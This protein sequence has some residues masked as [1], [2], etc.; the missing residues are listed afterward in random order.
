MGGGHFSLN[1]P[2]LSSVRQASTTPSTFT[3]KGTVAAPE[4]GTVRIP[5]ARGDTGAASLG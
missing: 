2:S 3:E 4:M 1:Q 5:W